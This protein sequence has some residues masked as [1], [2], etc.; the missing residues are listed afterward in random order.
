MEK[1]ARISGAMVVY[2]HITQP[3]KGNYKVTCI[4][5]CEEPERAK[6]GEITQ[7]Y[8][9]LLARNIEEQ[10]QGWLWSHKRWKR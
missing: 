9:D 10:P 7:K 2:L 8:V 6:E 5:L 3:A 4:T 1:L